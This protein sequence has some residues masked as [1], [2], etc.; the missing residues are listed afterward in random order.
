MRS[1]VF[2]RPD[3][4]RL[5]GTVRVVDDGQ[6]LRVHILIM[7]ICRNL[8]LGIDLLLETIVYYGEK[9]FIVARVGRAL[10]IH[11]FVTPS[12]GG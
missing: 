6:K 5:F 4:E 9:F 2:W 11:S 1:Y 10:L 7:R 3:I 8:Y 12:G